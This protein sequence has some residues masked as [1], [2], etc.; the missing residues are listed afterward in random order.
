ME[1]TSEILREGRSFAGSHT[2]IL[3][4]LMSTPPPAHV[5]WVAAEE[6]SP[7]R[8]SSYAVTTSRAQ[9]NCVGSALSFGPHGT[10]CCSVRGGTAAIFRG[11]LFGCRNL[12]QRLVFFRGDVFQ[13]Y[14]RQREGVGLELRVS[15]SAYQSTQTPN[16]STRNTQPFV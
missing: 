1:T 12:R 16:T 14:T 2:S 15:P 10:R 13:R 7:R 8:T 11:S 5:L 6:F 3:Q 9:H 4:Y